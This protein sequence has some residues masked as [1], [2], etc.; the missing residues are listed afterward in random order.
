MSLNSS[1]LDST[2]LRQAPGTGFLFV[3]QRLCCKPPAEHTALCNCSSLQQCQSFQSMTFNFTSK[4]KKLLLFPSAYKIKTK[5]KGTQVFQSSSFP[6]LPMRSFTPPNNFS[7]PTGIS[8]STFS[9]IWEPG[10]SY[11]FPNDHPNIPGIT[12]ISYSTYS[13]KHTVRT[14]LSFYTTA[15]CFVLFVNSVPT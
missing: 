12:G 6:I 2:V 13:P 10:S 4:L 14:L 5:V 1:S 15:F 7:P 11:L 9:S 3:S 8:I